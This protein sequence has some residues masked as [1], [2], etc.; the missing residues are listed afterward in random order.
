[1][2]V[3]SDRLVGGKLILLV[4]FLGLGYVDVLSNVSGHSI[5]TPYNA[6][7]LE[8]VTPSYSAWGTT[9]YLIGVANGVPLSRVLTARYGEYAVIVVGFFLYSLLS[10]LC[11]TSETVYFYTPMRFIFGM[12]GGV[13]AVVCQ[14]LAL[15]EIPE[16][17]YKIGLGYWSALGMLPYTFAV[18]M[19]GFWAEY[20]NWKWLFY[21]NSSIGI[22]ISIITAASLYGRIHIPSTIHF[23]TIGFI[24]F[25]ISII[26]LQIIF[27]Q[28]NDFD[29]L[30]SPWLSVLS[31]IVMTTIPLFIIWEWG[32]NYPIIDIR[33]FARPSYAAG[34]FYGFIGF[35]TIQGLMSLMSVQLQL[36]LG[37][38]SSQAGDMY[39]IMML[40]GLPLAGFMYEISKKF[41]VRFIISLV[42]LCS[43]ITLTWIGLFDKTASFDALSTPVVFL[44]LCVA[45]LSAPLSTLAT[46]GLSGPDYK[47]A[48]E[49]F[50]IMRLIGGALGI[51]CQ[52]VIYIRR[53][54]I[55]QQDLA[56][57][58]GGR[59][60]AS[61][62]TYSLLL[63]KFQSV[64]LSESIAR[65]QI[66]RLMRQQA[67]I[68]GF[69]D[70]FLVGGALLF[71]LALIV[72]VVKLDSLRLAKGY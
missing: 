31:L 72:W 7:A 35:F 71:V 6:G 50:L 8:G 36:L 64:G 19:G 27:S 38:S 16:D 47:R 26:S 39:L 43:S 49:E 66:A 69:N 32:E 53:L 55:H 58:L 63:Q 29:W 61:L 18:F 67:A 5:M 3:K 22:S 70:A 25:S 28:G 42:F 37:Y 9:L 52:S 48:G 57:Y 2:A 44:G 24:L 45:A 21:A 34:V 20:F 59:R 33:L 17:K 4:I 54:P 51:A 56:D 41:D 14:S 65:R 60:F 11:I 13:L 62:D 23:D 1:M 12:F 46:Y 15:H 40:A 68:L 10:L 30:A